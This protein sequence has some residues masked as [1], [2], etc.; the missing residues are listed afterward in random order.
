MAYRPPP[1]QPGLPNHPFRAPA[2]P[3]RRRDLSVC[4]VA[5]DCQRGNGCRIPPLRARICRRE[6]GPPARRQ[7]LA[8]YA[9]ETPTFQSDGRSDGVVNAYWPARAAPL[10]N[11]PA[12][13]QSAVVG[14]SVGG[15]RRACRPL[16]CGSWRWQSIGCLLKGPADVR[17]PDRRGGSASPSAFLV[18][19]PSLT[20]IV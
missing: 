14:A 17:A 15:M 3:T 16:A 18:W 9:A 20:A 2:P 6:R 10:V 7:A 13:L 11:F 1:R 12:W 19:H 4:P 5:S 8:P